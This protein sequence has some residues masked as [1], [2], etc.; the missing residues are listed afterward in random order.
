MD[1]NHGETRPVDQRKFTD[2]QGSHGIGFNH[3]QIAKVVNLSCRTHKSQGI[4][5]TRFQLDFYFTEG[6]S[7]AQL[8]ESTRGV[9][10]NSKG[11]AATKSTTNHVFK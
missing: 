3:F 10:I 1:N 9:I 11:M 4:F 7:F 5:F 8:T 6:V 2:I